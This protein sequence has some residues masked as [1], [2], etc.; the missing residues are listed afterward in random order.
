MAALRSVVD[1][2][3]ASIVSD[4]WGGIPH[5][6]YGDEDPSTM[7][8]YTAL[9]RRGGS[10]GISFLFASGDCGAQ[11]PATD[12]DTGASRPQTEYPAEDPWVTAVGGTSLGV[13]PFDDYIGET[14][15]GDRRSLL[16][17]NGANGQ[18]GAAGAT[19]ATWTPLPGGYRFGA[20]GGTSED[21]PQP[22]YQKG[23]VP[24]A[25]TRTLLTG[26]KA[27]QP[28]RV[29][30]DVAMAA[31]PMT[32]FLVGVSETHSGGSFGYG[33]SAV[34]GTSLATPLF[35]GMQALAQQSA[36]HPLGFLNPALYAKA[37]TAALHDV[38][39]TSLNTVSSMDVPTRRPGEPLLSVVDLGVDSTGRHQARLYQ[40]GDDGP[41][42]AA[43]GYDDVT[44]VGSPTKAY[45]HSW[46]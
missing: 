33:E 10:Q 19:C 32:G 34:G 37:G 14:G 20:G 30:P 4:S 16:V 42:A 24:D 7:A 6:V 39:A 9:F 8:A 25:L 31:D 28:M 5:S 38:T 1:G 13:G 29:L 2:R 12:C 26:A 35:A 40:L 46:R 11:D 15:W 41:L 18:T 3:L 45:L 17:P 22:A 44:G 43:P 23:M 27:A 36:G 21:V